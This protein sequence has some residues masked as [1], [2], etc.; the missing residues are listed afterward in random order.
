M[1][2]IVTQKHAD[3]RSYI[4][5]ESITSIESPLPEIDERFKFFNLWT[6]NTMPVNFSAEDPV[7][8]R[9]VSTSPAPLG[10]LFR[11][12]NYPPEK[13]LIDK[14]H[15]MDPE[16]L[17]AFE[18]QTGVELDGA[19][20]HPLMHTTKSIDFGIVL[21]GEIYLVLDDEEILL[22]PMDTVIQQGT[23]HAWSN[24]SNDCC[25]MA[26]VLLDAAV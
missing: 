5:S 10:S 26:Y 24:R 19:N 17:R 6:T 21:S 13:L 2:R 9:S 1:K 3:G 7:K 12:V 22:K 18:K 11:I 15:K 8:D 14:I 23:R 25:L 20:K 16:A 4:L